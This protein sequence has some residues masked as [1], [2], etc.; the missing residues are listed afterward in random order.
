MRRLLRAALLV[1][2]SCMF[3]L[4]ADAQTKVTANPT[5]PSAADNAYLTAY[6]YSEIE[7]GWAAAEDAWTLPMLLKFSIHPA[8]ELGFLMSGVLNYTNYNNN[9]ETETGTP[10]FQMKTRFMSTPSISTALVGRVEIPSD[11]DNIYTAYAAISGQSKKL[12]LDVTLGGIFSDQ[13]DGR[14]IYAAALAPKLNGPI[15]GFVEIFGENSNSYR[16]VS[17][18][19]GV[20][21]SFS[22]G[23]VADISTAFGLNDDAQDWQ[24]Q[25]G[26]T[27]VLIR[28]FNPE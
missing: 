3:P 15:G 18:D 17:M 16:P 6:G 13:V 4:I 14:F 11:A 26:F 12:A 9:S 19:F 2:I 8:A 25:I 22:P 24:F 5:R 27:S 20:S 10:G 21:Y 23:F 7:F 1:L 28:L